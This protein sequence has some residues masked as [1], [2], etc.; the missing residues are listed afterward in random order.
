MKQIVLISG[1]LGLAHFGIMSKECMFES[2]I[3]KRAPVNARSLKAGDKVKVH[4]TGWLNNNGQKGI[5]FDSSVD[6]DVPFEFVLGVGYVI[7]GWDEVVSQM[8]VGEKRTVFIP[9]SKAYGSRGAGA[10]IPANAD[11]IF[12]I[13]VLGVR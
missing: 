10:L 6:R 13:E 9:A 4:Y 3:T 7:K 12:D 5:K 1:V 11:L 2:K 8:K